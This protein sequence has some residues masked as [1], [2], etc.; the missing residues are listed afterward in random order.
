MPVVFMKGERRVGHSTKQENSYFHSFLLLLTATIWGVAFVAQSVGMDHVGPLTFVAARSVVAVVAL[1]PVMLF[2]SRRG[3]KSQKPQQRCDRRTFWTGGL[4]CGVLLFLGM[5]TQQIGLVYTTVGKAGFIT[6]TYVVLVPLLGIFL[7]RRIGLRMWIAV[8]LALA[9]LYFLCVKQGEFSI[10]LGDS[11]VLLCAFF[12]TIQITCVD[13]Y[14]QKIDSIQLNFMQMAV[15]AVLGIIVAVVFEEPSWGNL[16]AAALPI[17]YAGVCSS[18]MGFTFQTV[19]QEHVS[20]TVASLIMSLESCI[21]AIA[22]WLLLGQVLNNRELWGCIL[23]FAAIILSQ[24]PAAFWQ[25]L[26]VGV[27]KQSKE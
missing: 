7:G 1:V 17:L 3:K 4:L 11:I 22:G 25:S 24:L 23:M 8:L 18:A 14:V 21:S 10:G 20:P 6:T 27:R 9:G 2:F 15:C 26:T 12:Y 13:Y 16:L 19:A 5:I